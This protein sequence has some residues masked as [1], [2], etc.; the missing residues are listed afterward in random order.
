MISALPLDALAHARHV[1]RRARVQLRR[2]PV[3]VGFWSASGDLAQTWRRL[4]SVGAD[5]LVTSFATAVAQVESLASGLTRAEA[6]QAGSGTPV[7]S[8][9]AHA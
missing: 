3:I 7:P 9:P 8:P 6:A 1:T 4:E 2:M 5:R